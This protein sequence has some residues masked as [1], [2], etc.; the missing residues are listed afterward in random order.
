MEYLSNPTSGPITVDYS[1]QAYLGANQSFRVLTDPAT[2]ANRFGVGDGGGTCCTPTLG[3]VFAGTNA[4]VPAT[5]VTFATGNGFVSYKWHVTVPAGQTRV[6]MHFAAQRDQ[7]DSAGA[8]AIAQAL[9]NLTDPD[10]STGLT[11]A[12]TSQIVNFRI[13]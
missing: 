3:F 7:N 6:L 4:T 5:N 13:P 8:A 9:A 1:I 10:A 11:V 2:N 12:D